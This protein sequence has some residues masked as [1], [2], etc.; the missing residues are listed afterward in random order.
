MNTIRDFR[1]LASG[2]AL[3]LLAGLAGPVAAQSLTE[4][5]V[6]TYQSSPVLESQ[7]AALRGTDEGVAQARALRR[8][9]IDLEASVGLD[10]SRDNDWDL[11]DSYTAGLSASLRL[12]DHGQ[13]AAAIESAKANVASTRAVLRNVEQQV[14]LAAV[15]AF[16]DIRRDQQQVT[17]ARNNVSVLESQVQATRDRFDLG[18]VT[19]TDVS[20]AEARLA[21]AQAN[22]AA[23]QGNLQSALERYQAVVGSPATS[24]QS[25]PPLPSLP[26]SL[27]EAESIAMRSHP[28]LEAARF[29]QTAAEF[30]LVRARASR[31]PSVNLTGGLG[32]SNTDNQLGQNED[33]DLRL[34]LG[35]NVPLYRGGQLSSVVRQAEAAVD[36]AKFDVQDTART[37]RQNAAIAWSNIAVARATIVANREEVRAARIA[38]EGVSEEASL[39]AR[40]TLDV[41]DLEQDLRN[42]E[43][44]LAASQRDE[45]VAVYQLLSAM[46]LLSVD[47]LN[48]GIPTYEPD[49]NYNRV[50]N[51]PYSTVEG[52]ILDKLRDRYGR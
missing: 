27:A 14:L 41:L 3:W 48:L 16:M 10:A 17:T 6:T 42:A 51:A 29:A 11:A 2:A 5:L 43:F 8:P 28:S 21:L 49:I 4:T 7:R 52:S 25:P 13:S 33:I 19:R 32:I 36:R 18:E 1:V 31:G 12:Y 46:G 50:Q 38:F 37:I 45:Y 40:T 26:A 30:D 22:L 39:G 20:L 34:G 24:L 44:R 23:V 47:Y 15:A 9:S 35:A